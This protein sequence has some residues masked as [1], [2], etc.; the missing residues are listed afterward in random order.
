MDIFSQNIQSST[1]T[2]QNI[3]TE[4]ETM[5]IEQPTVKHSTNPTD[6]FTQCFQPESQQ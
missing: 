6:M 4:K 2:S 3:K 5:Q 1:R